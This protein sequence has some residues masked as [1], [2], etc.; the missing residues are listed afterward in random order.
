LTNA[1]GCDSVLT[2]NLTIIYSNTGSTTVHACDSY[3]WVENGNSTYTIS[4]DYTQMYTNDAGCDSLHTLN[5]TI[6]YSNTGSSALTQCNSYS[7]NGVTYTTSGAYVHTYTNAANCDSVHTLNLTIN[8]SNTGSSS[9]TSCDSYTWWGVTYTA[10]ANPTHMYTN[11]AGC[12]SLYTLHIHINY[13]STS[14]M[15]VTTTLS[16]FW[17]VTGQTYTATGS[18]VGT[19]HSNAVGCDSI[20]TLYI[21]TIYGVRLHAKVLLD[22]P[23]NST[24]GLMNDDLRAQGLL[25]LTE[26]YT[27]APFNKQVIGEPSGETT[28]NAVLAVTGNNAIVD[29]VYIEL[30]SGASGY[31]KVATRRALVQRDGDIVDMDGVSPVVFSSILPGNYFVTIKHRNHL[32]VM[33][34]SS[35]A[36]VLGGTNV[37]FTSA[38]LYVKSS[39]PA[40]INTPAKSYSG[41]QVLWAGDAMY[42]KNVKYNGGAVI[43]VPLQIH[44]NDKEFILWALGGV[45]NV[46]GTINSVYRAEDANM[47]GMIRYN[48]TNNDKNVVLGTV[49]ASTPNNIYNQHTPD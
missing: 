14:S 3:T 22:G 33:T 36:M 12:D 17:P 41:T 18:Y 44:S 8:Y 47:D 48:N 2:L 37:D 10:D 9:V 6:N 15:H 29:W 26:P 42:D 31:P 27:G 40:I 20:I 25:P 38:S 46:N 49:G 43:N 4:G 19:Y 23:Y 39:I 45:G 24:T 13:H 11:A 1:A 35:Q 32:G 7:W 30:R 28:T 34:S 16:Y 5:L 21:D